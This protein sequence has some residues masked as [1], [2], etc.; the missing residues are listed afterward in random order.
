MT[1]TYFVWTTCYQPS[2]NDIFSTASLFF[3]LQMVR[4]TMARL[5]NLLEKPIGF[6]F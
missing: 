3:A 2:V 4:I 5:K 6:K 1:R